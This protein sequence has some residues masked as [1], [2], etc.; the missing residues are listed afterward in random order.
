VTAPET[1]PAR[2]VDARNRPASAGPAAHSPQWGVAVVL[3]LLFGVGAAVARRP[4]IA[5]FGALFALVA[6]SVPA[7]FGRRH[8]PGLGFATGTGSDDPA[9]GR[10]AVVFRDASGSDGAPALVAV[11]ALAPGGRESA[12]VATAA[13]TVH[14]GVRV[15]LGGRR[16]LLHYR[17]S[18]FSTDLGICRDEADTG[19]LTAMLQPQASP[20]GRLPIPAAL[21]AHAG[22]HH[23]RLRG[24]GTEIRDVG[25][26]RH[27]DDR[28]H[29]DW[30]AT[31]RSTDAAGT[32]LV[33]RYLAPADAGVTLAVDSRVDV[34]ARIAAW[35]DPSQDA[36]RMVS[37]LQ[38]TRAAA[39][40]VAA[41]YTS[42]GDRVGLLDAF[43][44]GAPLRPA[45]GH[46]QLELLRRRLA[47]LA[48]PSTSLQPSRTPAPAPGSLVYFFSPLLEPDAASVPAHWVRSGHIVAVVDTL[49]E[50]DAAG[51]PAAEGQALALLLATR[52]AVRAELA[53]EG[54]PVVPAGSLR[55]SLE[56]WTLQRA[57]TRALPGA[58]P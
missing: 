5:V 36:L 55:A 15:P 20:L 30:R 51:L 10:R 31:A 44:F 11:R 26:L 6:V 56:L 18:A 29:I 2:V 4:D 53:T 37:S 25:P 28:R 33:R 32:P 39:G 13:E 14:L 52:A 35:V 58:A 23:A 7:R 12:L 17:V 47:A 49:P 46:R 43:G 38:L 1:V 48:V 16:E 42:R 40:S 9:R 57:R 21:R 19:V 24:G 27:G 22:S 3:A 45:G 50:I 8:A 54:I 41:A 34:P